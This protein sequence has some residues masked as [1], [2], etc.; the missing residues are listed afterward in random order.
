M[1]DW[2]ARCYNDK[3]LHNTVGYVTLKDKLEG[4]EAMILVKRQ[5][6]RVFRKNQNVLE[7]SG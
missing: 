4:R 7:T 6:A 5:Q 3:C 2:F 1:V